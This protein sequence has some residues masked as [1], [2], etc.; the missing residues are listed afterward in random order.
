MEEGKVIGVILID[1][2]KAFD[3]VNHTIL[4]YKLKAMS[5]TGDLLKDYLSN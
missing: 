3:P 4:G 5:I 1:F 2:Q